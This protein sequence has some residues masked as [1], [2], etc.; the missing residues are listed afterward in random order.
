[1]KAKK[2]FDII[3]I[4]IG[5]FNLGMAALAFAIP[6]LQCLFIDQVESFNWHP[7]LLLDDTRLQVPFYADLVT[8][9]DP[10]SKF[11]Y[12]AF[13]KAKQR[14]FRFAIHENYFP[15]RKEYNAYCRW[16][17]EQLPSLSFGKKCT[18]I[19]YCQKNKLYEITTIE[20][21]T[22]KEI[23]FH[24]SH[25]VIGTGT[26]P[27]LPACIG[28]VDHPLMFHSGNYLFKKEKLLKAKN[29]SIIGSGQSAA[30]IFNDLL[31]Q[32]D[33]TKTLNWFTR[34]SR[35]F[36]MEY[37]KL[38]LEMSSPDYISYFYDLSAEKKS[39]IIHQQN[40]LYKGINF[41]LINEI[42]DHLYSKSLEQD[43][44]NIGL[45]TNCNLQN[46]LIKQGKIELKFH[47]TDTGEFFKH[48]SGAVI[49]ATGYRNFIPSF[50]E[51]LKDH[52]QWTKD[53]L[54]NLDKNYCI[55]KNGKTIFVQNGDLHTHGFNSADLGLGPYRNAVILNAILGNEYFK[56]ENNVV[57]QSFNAAHYFNGP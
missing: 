44:K 41:S 17:A 33:K 28:S 57:F 19:T 47:H 40:N 8:L 22:G 7:G 9:A 50:L 34:S 39:T 42:Y 35:F 12:L 21:K 1:M 37:S 29:I 32:I 31:P 3:G 53:N 14:L 24:G 27:A 52:I 5:P 18:G 45:F 11:S 48:I 16:V 55:A 20:N 4:G 36:P 25:L 38:T 10:C 6:E 23:L 54:Y 43:V 15:T 30:E 51:P 49:L 46:L 26:T 2:I 56:M 13:L